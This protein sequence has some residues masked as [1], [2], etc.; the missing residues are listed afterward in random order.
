MWCVLDWYEQ[1]E[2]DCAQMWVECCLGRCDFAHDVVAL[3]VVRVLLNGIAGATF[4]RN[5]AV[6]CQPK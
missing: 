4:V 5:E 6:P 2:F 3:G 1:D